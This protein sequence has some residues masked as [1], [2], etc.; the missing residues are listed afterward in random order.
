MLAETKTLLLCDPT[1]KSFRKTMS[2]RSAVTE[3]ESRERE[4]R[5]KERGGRRAKRGKGKRDV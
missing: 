2:P 1:V 5:R 4:R 3:G